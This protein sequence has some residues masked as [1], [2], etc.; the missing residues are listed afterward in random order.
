MAEIEFPNNT[1]ATTTLLNQ[2][3]LE[4]S[5]LKEEIM[6]A[7]RHGEALL[8]S[9]RQL[10]GKATADRLGN[11][12][13]VERLLVQ[14]EETE[15]TFDLFWSHHSSRLRHCLALRQ[16]EQ[17]FREL[18]SSL[19]QHI[20]AIDDMTEVGETQNRIDQLLRDTSAFQRICKVSFTNFIFFFISKVFL[21]YHLY[22]CLSF[23][24]FNLES[25]L[26]L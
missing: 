19:D 20:K 23:K 5:E 10:T 21:L 7:A 4:Y 6:N 18:Q 11:V 26:I 3:Q 1:L 16:F 13:A 24:I 15:R 22:V 25:L 17:D 9:V 2:Q 14:L 8:D 12:A